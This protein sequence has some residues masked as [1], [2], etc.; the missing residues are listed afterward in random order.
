MK[1]KIATPETFTYET[2][3]VGDLVNAEVVMNAMNAMPPITM[4]RDC[5][6]LGEPYSHRVVKG[7]MHPTFATFRCIKGDFLKGTWEFCGYCFAGE[8]VERGAE[9]PEVSK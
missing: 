8:N 1:K 4:R 5:A 6:Q 2:A 7:R 3:Q 9:L